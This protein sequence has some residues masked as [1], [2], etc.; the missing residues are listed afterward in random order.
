[1][2]TSRIK[3]LLAIAISF[4]MA[5]TSVAT[6]VVDSEFE[7]AVPRSFQQSLIDRL[8][9]SL[10][11]D[12][13]HFDWTFDDQTYETP[14]VTVL[15]K[16]IRLNLNSRLQKPA[17][18]TGGDSV[19]LQSRGLEATLSIDSVSIDQWIER[20]VGGVIGRFRIQARCEGVSLRMLPGKA[21]FEMRLRPV[22]EGGRVRAK[23]EDISL[24]WLKDGWSV[25]ALNCTGAAGFENIIR[26]EILKQ[27][28]DS[29]MVNK[30]KDAMIEYVQDYVSRQSFDF[31]GSRSLGDIRPDIHASLRVT[32]FEGQRENALLRGT[33]RIVFDKSDEA[34]VDLSLTGKSLGGISQAALRVP[35]DIV[36]AISRRAFGAG[37][38]MKRISSKDIPGFSVLTKSRFVEFFVWRELIRYPRSAEFLFDVTNAKPLTLSGQDLKYKVKNTLTS[39]MYAPRDG[40]YVPFMDFTIPVSTD[41]G[42][43]IADGK[44]TA[45]FTNVEI[46]LKYAWDPEYLEKYHPYKTFAKDKILENVRSGIRKGTQFSFTLPEI[47]VSSDLKL[48]IQKVLPHPSSR[49]LIIYLLDELEA[50]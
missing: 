26:E 2:Q 5:Q 25:N 31:S 18:D 3:I 14:D 21:L 19:I 17:V 47:P 4:F 10:Q 27:V 39:Q 11:R 23:V 9:D 12:V 44:V 38:W 6:S 35:E 24:N 32:N 41:L 30:Y 36:P 20:E 40:K 42:V 43:T 33:I 7:M 34:D 49:D 22:F 28:S 29:A 45:K 50:S 48:R 16:G 13:F 15:L 8:W 46:D 1:M 37:S